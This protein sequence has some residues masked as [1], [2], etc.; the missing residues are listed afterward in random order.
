MRPPSETASREQVPA[1]RPPPPT[2]MPGRAALNAPA[3]PAPGDALFFVAMGDGSGRSRFA[4]T[5][6]EHQR[7]VAAYLANRR[8][9]A[10]RGAGDDRDLVRDLHSGR[11]QSHGPP[12]T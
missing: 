6:A 7:N 8:A 12:A 3:H 1:I 4:A 11:H 10:A 2:A 5:Y 9:D